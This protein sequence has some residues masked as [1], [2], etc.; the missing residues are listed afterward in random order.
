LLLA[1]RA[2]TSWQVTDAE[3]A[4][5]LDTLGR[6][7]FL[8]GLYSDAIRTL[9][10]SIGL[11]DSPLAR[12]HLAETFVKQSRLIEARAEMARARQMLDQGRNDA[13]VAEAREKLAAL[14]E[15]VGQE[16]EVDSS[17]MASFLEEPASLETD[18]ARDRRR[19]L[20]DEPLPAEP[21]K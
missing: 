7:Q 11:H 3:R 16:K 13:T 2:S 15:L 18:K 12:V 5:I 1:T 19:S 8:A 14:T 9:Q 17:R 6:V 4:N 20:F 21:K 10:E